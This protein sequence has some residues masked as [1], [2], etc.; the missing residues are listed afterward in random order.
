MKSI[1]NCSCNNITKGEEEQSRAKRNTNYD[2]VIDRIAI[3][4]L[5]LTHCNTENF[6]P[7]VSLST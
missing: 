1:E 4:L 6:L 7:L 2:R 3:K 5:F